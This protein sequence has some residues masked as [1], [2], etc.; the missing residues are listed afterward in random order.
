MCTEVSVTVIWRLLSTFNLI[1]DGGRESERDCAAVLSVITLSLC[2]AI[3][4]PS[5][6]I[7]FSLLYYMNVFSIH[8]QWKD[9]D[10]Y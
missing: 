10:T 1:E 8:F 2:N 3:Y 9:K 5:E 7:I 4:N 6:N